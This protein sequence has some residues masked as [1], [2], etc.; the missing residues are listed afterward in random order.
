MSKKKIQGLSDLEGNPIRDLNQYVSEWNNSF[1]YVFVVTDDL[2]EHER[3]VFDKK[4]S[5][6]QNYWGKTQTDTRYF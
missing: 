2:N 1:E 3:V 4:R 5:H 6:L